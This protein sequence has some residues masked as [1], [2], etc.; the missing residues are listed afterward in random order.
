MTM[1][2]TQMQFEQALETAD[3]LEQ[4]VR[5]LAAGEPERR[6]GEVLFHDRPPG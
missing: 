2:D 3:L 1:F 5:L 4:R 6:P